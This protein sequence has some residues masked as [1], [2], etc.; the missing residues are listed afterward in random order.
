FAVLRYSTAAQEDTV[1]SEDTAGPAGEASMSQARRERRASAAGGLALACWSETTA[2]PVAVSSIPTFT[3]FPSASAVCRTTRR[4][5]ALTPRDRVQLRQRLPVFL[6]VKI[7]VRG[8]RR[9]VP[10][11]RPVFPLRIGGGEPRLRPVHQRA[12]QRK[13]SAPP[14][15]SW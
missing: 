15:P 13:V 1:R 5:S 9:E 6:A 12:R 4:P 10:G 11:L 14:Q 2:D 8:A 7:R 3:A